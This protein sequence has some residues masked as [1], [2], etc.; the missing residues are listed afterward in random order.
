MQ[1]MSEPTTHTE[2][3]PT[4]TRLLDAAMRLIRER[5][6]NATTVDDLC[7][8]AGVTKGAFFHYF[9]SKEDL[10]ID[11]VSY[12]SV[13]SK[14]MFAESSYHQL[15]DPLDRIFGYIDL[16]AEL[17]RGTIVQFSCLI[18]TITQE[19]YQTNPRIREAC[20]VALS[21]TVD[22]LEIDIAAALELYRVGGGVSARSLAT[23]IQTVL[24]GAFIFAKAKDD[25]EAAMECIDHL[26]R[27]FEFL[28][29]RRDTGNN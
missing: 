5:G 10:A 7:A 21:E 11:T 24:Q 8:A 18:G 2:A 29:N 26:R 13:G 20:Y 15:K 19:V 1:K 27:Y 12:W 17:L 22:D 25:P 6:Y 23:H 3:L 4:R 9:K 14:N 16:R 28:F